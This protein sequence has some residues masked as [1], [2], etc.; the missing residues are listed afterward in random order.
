V[1]SA[2]KLQ[3]EREAQWPDERLVSECLK[4]S[5]EAWSAL[6][7]KYKNLI[8]SIPVKLRMY[9]DAADIFQAVCLDLLA[10]LPK[11]REPKALPKW[12]MQACY[13]KCLQYRRK[14]DKHAPLTNEEGEELA[15][16][17]EEPLPE[18]MLAEVEKEQTVRDAISQLNPRCEQMVRMLFF[19]DPPRPYEEVARELKLATGSIGFIRGRCLQ[20]LRKQLEKLG[21]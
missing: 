5:Q 6:I 7:D 14:S 2:A 4:G 18:R 15:I 19:D 8:Y 3:R 21:F 10:G 11:L 16:L 13:H 12:L 17:S 20:K 9:D 1:N